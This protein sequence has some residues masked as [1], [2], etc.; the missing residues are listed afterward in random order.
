MAGA[1]SSEE[2][3]GAA[4]PAEVVARLIAQTDPQ[5]R[6]RL[7]AEALR[8]PEAEPLL[9]QLKEE[10]ERRLRTEPPLAL[11][12][13]S[14][15]VHG[16]QASGRPDHAALGLLSEGDALRILG[17]YPESLDRY[18]AAARA[19]QALRDEV[20]WARTRIGRL[21][22]MH[23]LGRGGEA[24]DDAQPAR[25]I[26]LRHQEF[27]RA[28]VLDLNTAV[29]YSELGRYD[30][31]LRCLRR[32]EE[33]YLSAGPSGERF[34]PGARANRGILLTLL[35]DF[36]QAEPLLL[37]ARDIYE[38]RGEGVSVLRADNN[39]ATLYAAQGHFSRALRLLGEVMAAW[40]Q[41]GDSVSVAR[42]ALHTVDC[43]LRLNRDAEALELA[44]ET[45]ERFTRCGTPTEAAKAHFYCAIACSRLGQRERAI[46]LLGQA[47]SAFDAAGLSIQVGLA[48][49]QRARLQL[50]AGACEDAA[51]EA[52]SARRA[53]ASRG[54]AVRQ[55]EA[56]AL[57]ARA[58]LGAGRPE[59]ARALAESVLR[60]AQ[61]LDIP[62]LTYLGQQVL[63]D[64]AAAGGRWQSALNEYERAIES[65]EHVQSRLTADLGARYLDDKLE[66]YRQAI[67]CA[68]HLDDPRRAFATLERAKSRALVAY[69]TRNAEVRERTPD[70]RQNGLLDELQ[71]LRA[72]HA[73]LYDRLYGLGPAA[74]RPLGQGETAALQA[75]IAG[76]ERRIRRL[77]ER[78]LLTREAGQGP[79]P[80]SPLTPAA[81]PV[82]PSDTVLIEYWLEEDAGTAFVLGDGDLRAVPLPGGQRAA[83]RLLQ[84]WQI[85]LESTARALLAGMAVDGLA[86]NARGVLRSFYRLLLEPVAAALEGRR[87]VQIIPYGATHA[88]PWHALFDGERH[89][90]QRVEVAVSPSSAVL[91]L[92]QERRPRRPRGQGAL[93]MGYSDGGRLPAVGQEVQGVVTVLGGQCYA[94]GEATRA[95]LIAEAPRY[96]L[97]H[98][99]AHGE[100][101]LDSPEFAHLKLADG[102][103]SMTDV[104]NLSL[105]GALVTL[106]ACE[107][108]RSVV[109]GGDELI[110][111]ARGFLYAGAA[112]LVQSLWRVEDG[113]TARLMERFYRDLRHGG[114]A[115]AALRRAQLDLLNEG[116]PPYVWAPFQLVGDGGRG[117]GGD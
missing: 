84:L 17:R 63:G 72:E 49:L 36:G 1:T 97:I 5:A 19:F 48:A 38:R 66:V 33:A 28:A 31:A 102:Q 9:R 111:L 12:L 81:P 73:W 76:R 61:G 4:A 98:L 80:V 88:V 29:V 30:E 27:P 23:L 89:L 91:Q 62:W 35:G 47:A 16:A 24:L 20:G 7:L 79:A 110:G 67:A 64:V 18:D 22:T 77:Q 51:R 105:D 100:A 104:F 99:A 70:G 57:Q 42:A 13:A 54:A 65:I 39:L 82:L 43:Y 93:V 69:L 41:A 10:S 106:S 85:N 46:D 59:E 83:G 113:S 109:T 8:R 6:S 86:R 101:R 44:E 108:G 37:E 14:W 2:A 3:I 107:T 78:L 15:L 53:F 45:A 26:L 103:L 112:T 21:V 11:D 95:R 116:V 25:Q 58:S 34:V 96:D 114:S 74:E 55:A 60:V 52:D 40:E 68:L 94:E 92:C 87:A 90:L 75:E 32:A 56:E 115:G 50:E 71:A 117:I